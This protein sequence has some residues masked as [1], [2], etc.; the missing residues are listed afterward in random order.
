MNVGSITGNMSV[1]TL[2]TLNNLSTQNSPV[3]NYTLKNERTSF[4]NPSVLDANANTTDTPA[5]NQPLKQSLNTVKVTTP[6]GVPSH[7]VE[8]YS[9]QGKLRTKFE[10]SR[11]NVV[12]QVPSEMVAKMQDLMLTPD[13]STNIKG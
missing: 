12:Y 2:Q 9:P 8:S 4:E 13:T 11:N 10:D 5:S 1:S 3:M 6:A 7:I